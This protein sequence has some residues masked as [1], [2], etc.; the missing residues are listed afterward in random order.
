MVSEKR[1]MGAAP[2]SLSP[3]AAAASAPHS[4]FLHLRLEPSISSSLI[5]VLDILAHTGSIAASR[6]GT[7]PPRYE[8]PPPSYSPPDPCRAP[9]GD[10][11]VP[12]V[13]TVAESDTDATSV[14]TADSCRHGDSV[15]GRS[16]SASSSSLRTFGFTSGS[17]GSGGGGGCWAPMLQSELALSIIMY[18][19]L[20]RRPSLSRSR[21]NLRSR[22]SR[23]GDHCGGSCSM[24]PR[25]PV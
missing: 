3:G 6:P 23:A 12:A 9:A 17:G 8:P 18:E 20:T 10:A 24:S 1:R 4:T 13:A 25:P 21:C 5:E 19:F 16:P 11:D 2:D 22:P 15:M 7:P 14:T